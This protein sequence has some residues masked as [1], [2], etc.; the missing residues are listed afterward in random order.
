MEV[1][2]NKEFGSLFLQNGQQQENVA[3]SIVQSGWAKVRSW[4]AGRRQQMCTSCQC[5]AQTPGHVY[6]FGGRRWLARARQLCSMCTMVYYSRLIQAAMAHADSQGV[7]FAVHQAGHVIIIEVLD[8]QGRGYAAAAV[9]AAVKPTRHL[10][11]LS[12]RC[13]RPLVHSRSKAPTMRI[14]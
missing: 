9:A 6:C 12:C 5:C 1:A 11:A 4:W 14:W 3:L 13:V 10:F 8:E 2:G 7:Y